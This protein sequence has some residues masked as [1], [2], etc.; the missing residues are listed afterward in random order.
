[1]P[2]NSAP[3]CCAACGATRLAAAGWARGDGAPM[4]VCG[5][6]G[7]VQ[8]RPPA[9]GIA[10]VYDAQYFHGAEARQ[11]YGYAAYDAVPW[12]EA[13]WQIAFAHALS[14]VAE[15]RVLDVGCATGRFL[16]FCR[17][18]QWDA[19]GADVSVHAVTEAESRGFRAYAGAVEDLG[20]PDA[21]FDMI[22]CWDVLEHMT[23]VRAFLVECRRVLRDGGILLFSTPDCGGAPALRDGPDWIGYRSSYEHILYFDTPSIRRT[24]VGTLG[25]QARVSQ[26][27]REPYGFLLGC[28][29]SARQSMLEALPPALDALDAEVLRLSFS[30]PED[31]GR[32]LDGP[33]EWPELPK[34]WAAIASADW[35]GALE[36]LWHA[37]RNPYASLLWDALNCGAE[38]TRTADLSDET[39][40]RRR[41]A[42]LNRMVQLAISRGAGLAANAEVSRS[43]PAPARANGVALRLA[44]GGGSQ[45]SR[46]VNGS[47]GHDGAPRAD[48]G[49]RP[50]ADI[51][52]DAWDGE[53]NALGGWAL[54][55]LERSPS[56]IDPG[57]HERVRL[58]AEG[59]AAELDRIH[60]SRT[61]RWLSRG[62]AM[63]ARIRRVLGRARAVP[64][65]AAPLPSLAP[66]SPVQR[67]AEAAVACAPAYDV[68][69]MGVIDWG[70]RFQRPQQLAVQWARRG[71]RI[72][73]VE[74][75]FVAGERPSIES[76]NDA[77]TLVALS[78]PDTELSPYT[79]LLSGRVLESM[80]RQMG[81]LR[82]RL[83]LSNAIVV[84]DLPF[85]WPL[86]DLL[87]RRFG[88]RIIYDCMDRHSG[89]ETN[90]NAMLLGETGLVEGADA[91]VAS[92]P[93]LVED[94]KSRGARRSLLV[95]NAV[96]YGL[97]S[98]AFSEAPAGDDNPVV[99]G[100][101]G[102]IAHW[103]DPEPI[104]A[105][106]Q[107]NPSWRVVLVGDVSDASVRARLTRLPNVELVGEV[108]YGRLTSYL[109]GFT[110]CVIPFRLTPL[111]EATNPVKLFEYLAAGRP[112]ISSPLPDVVS[113][114]E[115]HPGAV[116]VVAS[117]SEWPAAVEQALAADTTELRR[118][119][120]AIGRENEWAVRGRQMVGLARSLHPAVSII[121]VCFNNVHYTE[122]CLRSIDRWGWAYPGPLEVILV[123]N[124]SADGT[125]DVLRRWAMCRT[126]VRVCANERNVGFAAANNQAFT[127]AHGDVVVFLNND[128][129][130][131]PGAIDRLVSHLDDASVGL[132][133]P[134]TN[135]IG[136]EAKVA[137]DYADL[138]DMPG[139]ALRYTTEHAGVT[140]DIAACALFCAA[141]RRETLVAIG[142]LD[143][144]FG[145]GMFEDDDLSASVRAMGLRV[146]CAE[147]AFVHHVGRA[148]F[149]Q[150]DQ[151]QYES[152]KARN[153]RLWEEKWGRE[154]VPHRYRAGV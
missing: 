128:A 150:L 151:E 21:S 33:P 89:F 94:V 103:F 95:P 85:W 22:T 69:V 14:P 56:G 106:A 75:H 108:P 119:R 66:D 57:E 16:H 148:A 153:R 144:R 122:E 138:A 40:L 140:F 90:T 116:Q 118:Y 25:G 98:Q 3:E 142:G 38:G 109:R 105:I 52:G 62:W 24:L 74:A 84:V 43:R 78:S 102:A 97:F 44:D 70:Y 77:I 42:F 80:A 11:G 112:C 35:P 6:C 20:L 23:D 117:A 111:T 50:S 64:Q 82:T 99:V 48:G 31:S 146:I 46:G 79:S 18:F 73:Y 65:E 121:V 134:I 129:F 27:V 113:L 91:T 147:D 59:L 9:G 15:P 92:S 130:L 47:A 8:V 139:F 10:G 126:N 19:V 135:E 124:G 30:H 63:R 1:M 110:V 88:W 28:W 49:R 13:L 71:H 149:S 87:R 2:S 127:W 86:A 67:P 136:N 53:G 32:D 114:A 104:E 152:L 107:H 133:G 61:W 39:G 145:V 132:V 143:E 36:S 45:G 58:R 81:D 29:T 26:R 83:G 54:R 12:T 93:V 131:G 5:R 51:T 137:V 115:Q 101:H 7:V 4:W 141:V 34:V 120:S 68:V 55:N 41:E 60:R 96:D 37:P 17:A 72:L 76:V 125:A 100:Y 154:W 123:D